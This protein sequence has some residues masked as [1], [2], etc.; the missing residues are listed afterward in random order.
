[1]LSLSPP[2]SL[3]SA[4]ITRVQ[5]TPEYRSDEAKA[6]AAAAF[7][8]AFG[9]ATNK[10]VVQDIRKL[11]DSIRLISAGFVE[12]GNDLMNFDSQRFKDR[13][14]RFLQLRPNWDYF[15]NEFSR[16]IEHSLKNAVD[17]IGFIQ[18]I[19]SIL[20]DDIS[21]C[22]YKELLEEFQSSIL[23][24]VD[25]RRKEDAGFGEFI[26][27]LIDKLNRFSDEID[28]ALRPADQDLIV[29]LAEV[30]AARKTHLD[31]LN[32]IID[33]V[34]ALGIA[35]TGALAIGGDAA[36]VTMTT[37]APLGVFM[38]VEPALTALGTKSGIEDKK[39]DIQVA[40][41]EIEARSN[42]FAALI[43]SHPFFKNYRH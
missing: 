33:E 17:A 20:S 26:S 30:R 6:R 29:K 8:N 7:S 43:D 24:R 10:T 2:A 15:H 42:E 31:K 28:A 14:D 3:I 40:E 35:C 13:D 9:D 37:L 36:I 4:T 34:K 1:M 41:V 39:K 5:G 22:T 19:S 25:H 12:V 18:H 21:G 23:P 27:G 38:A 11:C 16:A 32:V